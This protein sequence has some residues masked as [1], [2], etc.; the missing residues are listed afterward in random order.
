MGFSHPTKFWNIY[1][2]IYIHIGNPLNGGM[3]TLPYV[4]L[5]LDHVTHFPRYGSHIFPVWV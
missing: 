4:Y 2:Y 5:T 3:T 1:V